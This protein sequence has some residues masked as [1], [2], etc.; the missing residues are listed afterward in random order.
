VWPNTI[1]REPG[2]NLY[3]IIGVVLLIIVVILLLR[4]V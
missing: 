4:L 1:R 2:V 3:T